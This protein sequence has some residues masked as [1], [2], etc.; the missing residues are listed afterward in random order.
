MSKA[1][2]EE[3]VYTESE[4]G[5]ALAGAVIRPAEQAPRPLAVV[6]V[7]GLTGAF[8]GTSAVGIG[9]RLAESGYATITGNNRGHGFGAPL[10]TSSGEIVLGGGGWERFGDCLY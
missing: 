3:L 9:R 2:A 4:D 6:W 8:Y 10:R 7:H 1:Y 5:I